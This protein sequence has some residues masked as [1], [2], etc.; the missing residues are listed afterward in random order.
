MAQRPAFTTPRAA[1]ERIGV[2]LASLQGRRGAWPGLWLMCSTLALSAVAAWQRTPAWPLLV[3]AALAT[4]ASAAVVHTVR[5][6][7]LSAI[8]TIV[9]LGTAISFGAV[10]TRT[11]GRIR[12]HFAEYSAGE[13]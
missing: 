7:R 5:T 12:S 1:V 10:G 11:L 6:P 3:L 2:R 4:I 8:A 13:R 9:A